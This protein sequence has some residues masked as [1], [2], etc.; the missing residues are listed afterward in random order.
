MK[1]GK[2]TRSSLK[3]LTRLKNQTHATAKHGAACDTLG[4]QAVSDVDSWDPKKE[5]HCVRLAQ[6]CIDASIDASLKQSLGGSLMPWAMIRKPPEAQA[7]D[8][9]LDH[10]SNRDA[11]GEE[12]VSRAAGLFLAKGQAVQNSIVRQLRKTVQH[13]RPKNADGQTCTQTPP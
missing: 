3:K 12:D 7:M 9:I 6:Q 8:F 2:E 5:A 10:L 11:F 13:H 1:M 4:V